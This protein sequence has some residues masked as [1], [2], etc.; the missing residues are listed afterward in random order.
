[1]MNAF[2]VIVALVAVVMLALAGLAVVAMTVLQKGLDNLYG[3]RD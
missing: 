3:E 1:M 2:L